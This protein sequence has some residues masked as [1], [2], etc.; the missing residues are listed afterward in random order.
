VTGLATLA[1]HAARACGL[2]ALARR[3]TASRLR[4]LCYHG[5]ALGDEAEFQPM[6]FMRAETFADRLD[7]LAAGGYPV[8]PLGAAIERLRSGRL[9]PA[10][11]AVTIDDGWYGTALRMAPALAGH[12]FPATLYVATY[13]LEKQ[14]Q[15]FNVAAAYAL[16]KAR[17]SRVDLA[18]VDDRLEGDF[19]L[20][21]AGQRAEAAR[22]LRELADALP[23]AE[24]RQALLARLYAVLGLDFES[25]RNRRMFSFMTSEEAAELPSKGIELQIHTHRHRFPADDAA[26]LA[27]EIE[28]NRRALSRCAA[29]PFEH[30]CYPSGEYSRRAF[31]Q[32]EALGIASAT[33][34]NPG[35][36]TPSTPRLELRRFLDSETWPAIRFEAE[37]SGFLDLL[38]GLRSRAPG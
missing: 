21:D 17:S 8:L 13:Y 37:I 32:L 12:G 15:V 16:W 30:L 26:A 38:R 35:L 3:L 20:V 9:P 29:G 6:L 28:D 33:T 36:N 14:T 10:A 27:A 31:P 34:T 11:V 2:F 5:I 22:R 24:T 18:A 25:V 4:I 7:R 19:A 23:C 1:L